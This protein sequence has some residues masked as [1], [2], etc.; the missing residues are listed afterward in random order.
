MVFLAR[1]M[2]FDVIGDLLAD[3]RQ[4]KQFGFDER[5]IGALDKSP[6]LGRLIL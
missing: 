1:Q 6:I 2:V 5:I 4:R 3:R